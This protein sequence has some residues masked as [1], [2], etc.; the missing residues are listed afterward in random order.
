M[1]AFVDCLDVGLQGRLLYICVKRKYM[2]EFQLPV[3]NLSLVMCYFRRLAVY[4]IINIADVVY[5]IL[6][7]YIYV[8][9][10]ALA[11]FS[12]RCACY[13][14]ATI[15]HEDTPPCLHLHKDISKLWQ[16]LEVKKI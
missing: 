10:T 13:D 15:P 9:P 6:P 5:G 16:E 3:K 1:G 14:C 8:L 12:R 4:I 7:T 2:H 11:T